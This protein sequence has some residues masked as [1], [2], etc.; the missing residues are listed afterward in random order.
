[1]NYFYG[2]LFKQQQA[3]VITRG[4]RL[5]LWNL[6]CVNGQL[7]IQRALR[8]IWPRVKAHPLRRLKRC[9]ETLIHY[10]IY[11]FWCPFRKCDIIYS[12]HIHITRKTYIYM[13]IYIYTQYCTYIYIYICVCVC[14][15]V[16]TH[17]CIYI[18]NIYYIYM[19][20]YLISRERKREAEVYIHI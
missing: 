6:R 11:S 7:G 19:I 8:S 13:Y 9:L 12:V 16:H 1:M 10:W 18:Y 4:N 15:Y 5:L 17:I 20:R 3:T 14:A 2:H